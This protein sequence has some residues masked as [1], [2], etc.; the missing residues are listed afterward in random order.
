MLRAHGQR[1]KGR[2]R[3]QVRT[4]EEFRRQDFNR[5]A[6][7]RHHRGA[8]QVDGLPAADHGRL[9]P[10][11]DEDVRVQR[12]RGRLRRL[13]LHRLRRERGTYLLLSKVGS[14][15]VGNVRHIAQLPILPQSYPPKQG[16]SN[17]YRSG[18]TISNSK[19]T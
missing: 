13:L 14:T 11:Q 1:D 2:G 18:T 7:A 5:D 4:K 19:S 16:W 6:Q 17:S 15:W 3:G 9:V 10:P 8:A 12:R